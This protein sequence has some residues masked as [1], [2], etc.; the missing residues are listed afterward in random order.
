M[1][2]D[3]QAWT[4]EAYGRFIKK[5]CHAAGYPVHFSSHDLR[6]LC[7]QAALALTCESAVINMLILAT[8][9]S[10]VQFA[11]GHHIISET[12][13]KYC[14]NTNRLNI[15]QCIMGEGTAT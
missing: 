11:M 10:D 6:V 1:T 14:S 15:Q 12:W 9:L 4:A 7:V 13:T 5:A 3:G 2:E 8:R